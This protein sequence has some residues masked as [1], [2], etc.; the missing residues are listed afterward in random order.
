M[1]IH[2]KRFG[3]I[4]RNLIQR[5]MIRYRSSINEIVADAE[6]SRLSSNL[7]GFDENH[8]QNVSHFCLHIHKNFT[9]CLRKGVYESTFEKLL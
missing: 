4:A 2:L 6:I 5:K 1:Y 3:L 9:V 7:S 8:L